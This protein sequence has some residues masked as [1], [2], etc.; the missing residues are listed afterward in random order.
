MNTKPSLVQSF[1]TRKV[2]TIVGLALLLPLVA[3]LGFTKSM[4][5]LHRGTSLGF[6]KN[7]C[8]ISLDGKKIEELGGFYPPRNGW[9]IYYLQG[10]HGQ[11]LFRVPR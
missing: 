7:V 6:W 3:V 4:Y 2:K 9:C 10:Y 5:P 8:G 1:S 11:F